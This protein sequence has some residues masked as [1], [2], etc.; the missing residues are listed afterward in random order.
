VAG[1]W[2]VTYE[3][4]AGG[5]K[6]HWIIDG[7]SGRGKIVAAVDVARSDVPTYAIT[8]KIDLDERRV[9][10]RPLTLEALLPDAGEASTLTLDHGQQWAELTREFA[11][12]AGLPLEDASR[13]YSMANVLR[14]VLD[15][16]LV[17]LGDLRQP[18]LT[19]Y[20]ATDLAQ[21]PAPADGSR[22]PVLL[23]RLKNGNAAGRMRYARIQDLFR[24][25][26]SLTF[27][28]SLFSLPPEDGGD[29]GAAAVQIAIMLQQN[30][31]DLPI[32]AYIE[33]LS[34]GSLAASVSV[35]GRSKP[36]QG[37]Y[38]AEI[39]ACPPEI[40]ALYAKL[41]CHLGVGLNL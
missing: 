32:E 39:I 38:V 16:G 17:L 23:F 21:D 26:T 15:K 27:D 34:P 18:P 14:V 25:L 33:N 19:S 12:S 7:P 24:R 6:F 20:T 3:F 28:I 40:D 10:T 41:I 37:R 1:V 30:G 36:R 31:R 2:S 11:Q 29:N 13:S 5:R 35:V 9:P 22:I 4:G 8:R